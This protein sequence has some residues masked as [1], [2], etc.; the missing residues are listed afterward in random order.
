MKTIYTQLLNFFNF[1]Y[2]SSIAL[3]KNFVAN[4]TSI[5]G[6][7]SNYYY[8]LFGYFLILPW[9]L[10]NKFYSIILD[11]IGYISFL[12]ML[13][14]KVESEK[15]LRIEKEKIINDYRNEISDII[16]YTN[17]KLSFQINFEEIKN[18]LFI[19]I[20]GLRNYDYYEDNKYKYTLKIIDK[21]L[22]DLNLEA[23]IKFCIRYLIFSE[24]K[25]GY[26]K[27]Y[28]DDHF[29]R[30]NTQKDQSNE[31]I[32]L[33]F[34]S[35]YYSSNEFKLT[36]SD[37]NSKNIAKARIEQIELIEFGEKIT[38]KNIENILKDKEK[39]EKLVTLIQK[40]IHKGVISNKS[41]ES[42]TKDLNKLL[43]VIKYGEGTSEPDWP[44]SMS[45]PFGQILYENNFK[46]PYFH[47]KFSFFRDLDKYP[48]KEEINTFIDSLLSKLYTNYGSL[49]KNPTYSSSNTI[50]TGPHYEIFAF[51]ADK[52]HFSW[53]ISNTRSNSYINNILLTEVLSGNL[54][55]EF[56][57]ANYYNINNVLDKTEWYSLITN[58]A[59]RTAIAENLTKVN[60]Q[61]ENNNLKIETI[62][63]I[64]NLNQTE[65]EIINEIIFNLIK[66]NRIRKIKVRA[67]EKEKKAIVK[68]TINQLFKECTEYLEVL[69]LIKK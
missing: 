29:D 22:L 61:F 18:D 59:I 10:D 57:K 25:T 54:N 42:I 38:K 26:R 2:W 46:N 12:L 47:D 45:A 3:A 39:S 69:N 7:L 43:V 41:L 31:N 55:V 40:G 6:L 20:K 53:R 21:S 64:K 66:K 32:L 49:K 13:Q 35:H 60:K 50:L 68:K 14:D 44:T 48:I 16:N 58:E 23:Q 62:R 36:I 65:L 51:A 37:L 1:V 4:L 17:T 67:T 5:N 24:L 52:H 11:I 33:K 63:D 34:L 56:I 8:L 28:L 30:R 9:F 19:E 27:Q 15:N